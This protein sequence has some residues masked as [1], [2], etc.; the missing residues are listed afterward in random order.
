MSNVSDN[1][2]AFVTTLITDDYLPG[3]LILNRSI[4][5]TC[6]HHLYVLAA[7]NLA[8]GTYES[9]RCC[10]IPFCVADDI[11]ADPALFAE[12]DPAYSHWTKTLFKLRI[13]EL[14]QFHKIVFIDCDIMVLVPIDDLFERPDM[15]AAVA[16][17][18]FPGNEDWR[19]LASGVLV[20]EPRAG[21]IEELIALVP[22]V[23]SEKRT[24]GDQDV[25]IKYFSD[26][27]HNEHLHLSESYNVFFDHY[28]FYLKR[29]EVKTLHFIGRKKPWMMPRAAFL[30][31][32][33]RCIVKG[34]SRGIVMLLR[35]RRYQKDV[36]M[37]G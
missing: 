1:G 28:Q 10:G 24:F 22:A 17:G 20:V 14:T 5:E 29:G 19:D 4:L 9:L 27:P 18:S 16:G 23:A 25:L 32:I 8:E 13:F 35:Y 31:Q 12:S 36:G 7:R 30:I 2:E 6:K 37:F 21:I 11:Y 34:N 15:S 33:V 26:W 3:V